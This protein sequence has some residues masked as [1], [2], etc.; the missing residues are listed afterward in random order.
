MACRFPI[1]K[2][3]RDRRGSIA[4]QTALLLVILVGFAAFGVEITNLML[5]QRRMQAAADAAAMAGGQAGR[6]LAQARVDA[7]GI[8]GS[9]GYVNGSDNV[10]I[11]V[12]KPA[13]VG[14]YG[15][16]STE[17]IIQKSF[18]P[19]LLAVL[20]NQAITVR[21]R[22]I[23]DPT[24]VSAG[25]LL[26][27]DP[28]GSGAV[29]IVNNSSINNTL[30]ELVVN[31]T[32]SSALTLQNSAFILGPVYL[33]GDYLLGN[34]ANITGTPLTRNAGTPVE[35]PY[36]GISLP[37]APGC[38][39]RASA[40]SGNTTLQ[41]GRYC[42]GMVIANN[43]KVTLNPGVYYI[44]QAFT[45]NQNSTVTGTGVT[46][47]FNSATTSTIGQ[48]V[49]LTLTAPLTG[50]TA[51][52]AITSRPNVSGSFA[53]ENN[54]K[55]VVEGAIYLPAMTAT[56]NNADTGS[57]DK[58]GNFDPTL[59]SPCTQLIAYRLVLGSKIGFRADCNGTAVR[60]IGRAQ[61]VLVQ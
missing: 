32:S 28:S 10:T 50:T 41:P 57:I 6:T 23:S 55:I 19:L 42:S 29:T 27:L 39:G 45:M 15:A 60:P 43:S 36:A 35:D 47:L 12:N 7:L 40:I 21:V 4:V 61:P 14:S 17:V 52:L 25:C 8:A 53:F 44:D 24:S 51:G 2:A 1:G 11:T 22:A 16:S 58:R 33:V 46:L 37:T 26:A 30:C 13:S 54:S 9:H 56:I 31:S 5:Q 3:L 38:P 48:G 20:T 18:S 59:G 34:G 49:S